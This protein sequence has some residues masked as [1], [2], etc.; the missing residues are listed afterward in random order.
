MAARRGGG[1]GLAA[2]S[3]R[4]AGSADVIRHSCGVV[5]GDNHHTERFY[6]YR[7]DRPGGSTYVEPPGLSVIHV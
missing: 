6:T 7:T 4:R 3:L 2:A 5:H 1:A